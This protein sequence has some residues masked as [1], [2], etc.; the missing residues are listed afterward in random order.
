MLGP[1]LFSIYT[2]PVA[3]IISKYNLMFHLYA[4]NTKIYLP[5]KPLHMDVAAAI[6]RIEGCVAE[7]RAWMS[8]NF[9]KLND[10]KTDDIIFGSA[11]QLEKID[12]HVI[13]IG[14]SLITV[15]HN[16]WNLGVQFDETMTM[17]SHITTVCK[18]AI[19]HLRNIASIRRYLTP[20]AT[21][22]I[23]HAFVTSRL[24]VDNALL[25]R[26]P[27]K[28]IQ[29]LQRVQHWAARLVVGHKVLP[30]DTATERAALAV[31]IE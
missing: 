25:Y 4:D 5:V 18:Y 7:I 8:Y 2:A 12:L 24:D 9:L 27:F 30:Q 22:Q 19:Y 26:L 17:E 1:Q 3:K 14:D 21:Q 10:D 20:S 28:Q 29:R 31:R 23:V 11:Q 6:E 13:P 15:S 16:M